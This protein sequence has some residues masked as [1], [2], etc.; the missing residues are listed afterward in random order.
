MTGPR[1][2]S[3]AEAARRMGVNKSTVARWIAAGKVPAYRTPGGHWRIRATDIGIQ[4]ATG[5][6][7]LR[8]ASSASLASREF[9]SA[10]A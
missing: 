6:G 9:C 2:I 8:P 10:S 1:L 7:G 5:P 4:S 3:A